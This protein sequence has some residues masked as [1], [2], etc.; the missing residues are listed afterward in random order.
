MG[1]NLLGNAG[2]LH[3]G[4]RQD[5]SGDKAEQL[6]RSKYAR[7]SDVQDVLVSWRTWMFVSDLYIVT[8]PSLAPCDIRPPR[9]VEVQILQEQI[10]AG[11][12]CTSTHRHPWLLPSYRTSCTQKRPGCQ[13]LIKAFDN[14][15]SIM[16][17][18]FFSTVFSPIP[19]TF[20]SESIDLNLP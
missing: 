2:H 20:S 4:K 10:S 16:L 7:T 8:P 3:G 14:D 19:S 18:L 9:M 13:A 15:Y 5:D 6:P 12:S 1:C 17:S 11:A